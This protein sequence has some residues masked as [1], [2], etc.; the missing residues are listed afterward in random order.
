M[1]LSF[2]NFSFEGTPVATHLNEVVPREVL[3]TEDA[4]QVHELVEGANLAELMAASSQLPYSLNPQSI[5][6]FLKECYEKVGID[7]EHITPISNT[8]LSIRLGFEL[9]TLN[10]LD[11]AKKYK[12][13]FRV[14]NLYKDYKYVSPDGKSYFQINKYLE[15]LKTAV[16]TDTCIESSTY[17]L[18]VGD[19]LHALVNTVTLYFFNQP[20]AFKWGD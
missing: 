13:L 10:K 7:A 14:L 1:S 12:I 8:V 19:I 2:K 20:H 6:R 4:E 11:R 9:R 18:G 5:T 3:S 16:E 17:L 15:I